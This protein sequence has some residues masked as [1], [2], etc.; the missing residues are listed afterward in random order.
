MIA[1]GTIIVMVLAVAGWFQLRERIADQGVQAAD[2]C[3]EG[4][5]VVAVVVEPDLS[6]PVSALAQRFTDGRPVVRDQCISVRV[7]SADSDTVAAA[8]SAGASVWDEAA[9]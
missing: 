2:T 4:D 7:T 3:V 6:G 5:A 9:L 8:I 1:V